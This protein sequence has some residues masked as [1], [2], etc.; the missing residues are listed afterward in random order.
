MF[1]FLN[2]TCFR[3]LFR[4]GPNGFNVP[5]GNYK[6]PEIINKSHLD[7]IH[8]LIQNVQFECCD[9]T[10]SLKNIVENDF[11]Y[12]DPPYAPEKDTSFIKYTNKGFGLDEHKK[13]FTL[14]N[15]LSNENKKFMMSNADVKLVRDNFIDEKYTLNSILCKRTINSKNPESKTKEVI[16][17]NY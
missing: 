7:E 9:F 4:E 5:Y 12:L 17:K 6:N 8:L 13:L 14:C 11:V 15:N 16:I 3:G 10:T 2:K 1:I